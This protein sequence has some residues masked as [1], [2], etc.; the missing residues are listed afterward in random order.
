MASNLEVFLI[1]SYYQRRRGATA[2][3]RISPPV[4]KNRLSLALDPQIGQSASHMLFWSNP[5]SLRVNTKEDPNRLYLRFQLA[6]THELFEKAIRIRYE[7]FEG[8][9]KINLEFWD[10]DKFPFQ[11]TSRTLHHETIRDTP[12]G[13]SAATFPALL[14]STMAKKGLRVPTNERF[15][16]M[17]ALKQ[18]VTIEF[19]GSMMYFQDQESEGINLFRPFSPKGGNYSFHCVKT[20]SQIFTAKIAACF[21]K[22]DSSGFI[23]K[24]VRHIVDSIKALYEKFKAPLSHG[25]LTRNCTAWEFGKALKELK[26]LF[27]LFVLPLVEGTLSPEEQARVTQFFAY[28]NMKPEDLEQYVGSSSPPVNLAGALGSTLNRA[29]DSVQASAVV[30]R[31]AQ[32]KDLPDSWHL[33]LEKLQ[34]DQFLKD[35]LSLQQKEQCLANSYFWRFNLNSIVGYFNG[36]VKDVLVSIHAGKN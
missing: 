26:Q 17:Q 36:F 16:F 22:R 15:K 24:R 7:P 35:S 2:G 9:W 14:T 12:F 6:Y 20:E 29:L 3:V 31:K 30:R 13:D 27:E 8:R 1:S 32:A 10:L 19:K 11:H 34:I 21:Y 23:F 5:S 4:V 18:P 33:S 28:A 25:V